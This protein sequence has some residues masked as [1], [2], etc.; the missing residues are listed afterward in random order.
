MGRVLWPADA[1][2]WPGPPHPRCWPR[3]SSPPTAASVQRRGAHAR[4]PCRHTSQMGRAKET[5][6]GPP[7]ARPHA[8]V[9]PATVP[10]PAPEDIGQQLGHTSTEQGGGAASSEGAGCPACRRATTPQRNTQTLGAVHPLP[11]LR[12]HP[13]TQPG[14]LIV[15]VRLALARDVGRNQQTR[16]RQSGH[17]LAPDLGPRQQVACGQDRK[18]ARARWAFGRQAGCDGCGPAWWWP[19]GHAG[20]PRAPKGSTFR[21]DR[22]PRSLGRTSPKPATTTAPT[23]LW[24]RRA[25]TWTCGSRVA[26]S[27]VQRLHPTTCTHS[28]T[29]SR[30]H[31]ATALARVCIARAG[32]CVRCALPSPTPAGVCGL[33]QPP[34]RRGPHS[35]T[36][37]DV[38]GVRLARAVGDDPAGQA[39]AGHGQPLASQCWPPRPGRRLLARRRGGMGA[40]SQ[41]VARA[42]VVWAAPPRRRC[43]RR[44]SCRH[45]T[46]HRMARLSQGTFPSTRATAWPSRVKGRQ[47]LQRGRTGQVV[48]RPVPG[49]SPGPQA[50]QHRRR[51]RTAPLD[52]VQE[53]G[54]DSAVPLVVVAGGAHRGSSARPAAPGPPGGG[55]HN[56]PGRPGSPEQHL[57]QDGER[58][59]VEKGEKGGQTVRGQGR[60]SGRRPA[61][62]ARQR[63]WR[64]P[65]PCAPARARPRQGSLGG[66]GVLPRRQGGRKNADTAKRGRARPHSSIPPATR[67]SFS[68]PDR[69]AQTLCSVRPPPPLAIPWQASRSRT[70]QFSCRARRWMRRRGRE[71]GAERG[72][73][74]RT[75]STHTQR[76]AQ[77]REHAWD[78]A[79]HKGQEVPG[80]VSDPPRVPT[81]E[82]EGHASAE[83]AQSE[84]AGVLGW[85]GWEQAEH[86]ATDSRPARLRSTQPR[87]AWCGRT[88]PSSHSS[89]HTPV[90]EA[91]KTR[92]APAVARSASSAGPHRCRGPE[93]EQAGRRRPRTQAVSSQGCARRT[94]PTHTC[95]GCTQ[96]DTYW[97]HRPHTKRRILPAAPPRRVTTVGRL[98][99]RG[100]SQHQIPPSQAAGPRPCQRCWT[101]SR[102]DL[103]SDTSTHS[104]GSGAHTP[105]A[106][107]HAS[108]AAVLA[109]HA[110]VPPTYAVTCSRCPLRRPVSG[111]RVT[112]GRV[113]GATGRPTG[114]TK[115]PHV[116]PRYANSHSRAT[117]AQGGMWHNALVTSSEA[118]R[119]PDYTQQHT[120]G[121]GGRPGASGWGKKAATG[122]AACR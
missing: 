102:C 88:S 118:I 112:C 110:Q 19:P 63:A 60:S 40:R 69:H 26:C 68:P 49:V 48:T 115:G 1:A 3:P 46:A 95:A 35:R 66:T 94:H 91:P 8:E 71:H 82:L 99:R 37:W 93:P 76:V 61:A 55:G 51:R 27:G 85:A 14:P 79:A 64:H 7:S 11:Q 100:R 57:Q 83:P 84:Q 70:A 29:S 4:R 81:D 105:P 28:C 109:H 120:S 119:R 74:S 58:G 13:H 113:E 15:H 96:A 90:R 47:R 98:H 2:R 52:P 54:Q 32:A 73:P 10:S 104:A 78:T 80:R 107:P 44:R 121:F 77:G 106:P 24:M 9:G 43:N 36:G 50:V 92:V 75:T 53:P 30:L 62:R 103:A 114:A 89:A 22:A 72:V 16:L 18:W 12:R 25:A 117:H 108:I 33:A 23:S 20:R 21:A 6:A 87:A 39:G 5:A 34:C 97:R 31:T 111:A 38:A 56:H 65:G 101:G 45:N 116:R 67:S 17:Q 122:E 41:V 42:R 59:I 86:Q